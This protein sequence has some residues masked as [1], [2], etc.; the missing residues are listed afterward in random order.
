MKALL[1]CLGFVVFFAGGFFLSQQTRQF[2]AEVASWTDQSRRDPASIRRSYDFSEL[3][4]N[5]LSYAAKQRLLD[6][7]EIV[8]NDQGVGV[9][10]GHFVIRGNDGEK[11]FACHRYSTVVMTFE[12]EGSAVGGE[13][14]KLEVEGACEMSS[15]INRISA[16]YIPVSRIIGEPVADGE[17]DFREGREIK[18]RFANVSDQWPRIWQLQ[19]VRLVDSSGK[20]SELNVSPN[21]LHELLK[22]PLTVNF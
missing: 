15:D 5:A 7:A 22:K 11:E 14:P 18:L 21:E 17:F 13:L 2:P 8:R 10:L 3:Q 12:G 6:G 19:S 9:E 1:T 20:Y 4:G 16:L